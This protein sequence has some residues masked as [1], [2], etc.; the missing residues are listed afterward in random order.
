M[1]ELTLKDIPDKELERFMRWRSKVIG[2]NINEKTLLATDYTN[3]FNEIIML[4]EMLP[5]MPDM[6]EDCKAWQPKSYQQHFRDVDFPDQNVVIEAYQNIPTL[7]RQRFENTVAQL[8]AII[9]TGLKEIEKAIN[10]NEEPLIKLK[11]NLVHN[12]AEKLS[13]VL[14][15][16]IHG[17]SMTLAQSEVDDLIAIL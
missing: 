4:I 6:L 1:S 17:N 12:A 9:L 13:V 15:G 7:F 11:C 5:D 3:H 10:A 14:N 16:L 2:L 8:N